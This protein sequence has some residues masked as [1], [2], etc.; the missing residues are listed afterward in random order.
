MHLTLAETSQEIVEMKSCFEGLRW[1]S[2]D[3]TF[4]RNVI[5]R[6]FGLPLAKVFL[7]T[8]R[9]IL[10]WSEIPVSYT[11]DFIKLCLWLVKIRSVVEGESR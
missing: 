10:W 7:K 2:F 4:Y 11:S 1:K 5:A 9:I 6:V 8:E 3:H